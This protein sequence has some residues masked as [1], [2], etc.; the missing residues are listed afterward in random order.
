MPHCSSCSREIH[1]EPISSGGYRLCS[2]CADTPTLFCANCEQSF[3][4]AIV[5]ELDGG[6]LCWNCH[7]SSVPR[8]WRWS[9]PGK[10]YSSIFRG[11][12]LPPIYY[13][14]ELECHYSGSEPLRDIIHT[15]KGTSFQAVYDGSL[16]DE[17]VEFVSP[18]LVGNSGIEELCALLRLIKPHFRVTR[19]CGYHLHLDAREQE[20]EVLRDFAMIY[21]KLVPWLKTIISPSRR[22]TAFGSCR[23]GG[24]WFSPS[25][26]INLYHMTQE[27]EFWNWVYGTNYEGDDLYDFLDDVAG[28]K[29]HD[30]RY[31]QLN[32]HSVVYQGSIEIRCHQG[33]LNQEKV[34]YWIRLWLWLWQYVKDGTL[35]A[36][37]IKD[38]TPD[39]ELGF[40]LLEQHRPPGWEK[41]VRFYRDRQRHF[42][43]KPETQST[44]S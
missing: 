22:E 21:C 14:I 33:T 36:S 32:F 37:V 43:F 13:G 41:I 34:I 39:R 25:E 4:S 18:I 26:A 38:L 1:G 42:G 29:Y 28:S 10:D 20:W 9:V 35:D 23:G 12:L 44:S 40:R 5:V 2:E 19:S 7:Y 24:G 8:Q 11:T 27:W 31:S 6:N 30:A 3:P 16:G 15:W 17:G